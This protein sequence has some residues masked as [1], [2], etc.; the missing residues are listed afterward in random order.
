ME[1]LKSIEGESG[2]SALMGA[3]KEY[4]DH[5]NWGRVLGRQI[6]STIDSSEMN[7][8]YQ[9]E[10]EE[11]AQLKKLH[12][13]EDK[14]G[15]LLT[16]LGLSLEPVNS[17]FSMF[18]TRQ[19]K[20]EEVEERVKDFIE[21][22]GI[23][24]EDVGDEDTYEAKRV[25]KFLEDLSEEAS[26]SVRLTEMRLNISD[27]TKFVAYLENLKTGS[28]DQTERDSLK[29]LS[30]ILEQQLIGEYDVTNPSDDRFLNLVGSLGK[31]VEQYE[32]L[33]IESEKLKQLLDITRQG[34]LKDFLLVERQN[35]LLPYDQGFGPARWHRDM[36][37]D[38]YE[39]NW[40]KAIDIYNQTLKN[41]K[42]HEL[43]EKLRN[44]LLEAIKIA[45]G[46]IN[47]SEHL[48]TNHSK[49]LH[50]LEKVSTVLAD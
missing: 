26:R 25:G 12:A 17:P 14:Y 19:M 7:P 37:D 1:K 46:E 16:Q 41:P 39:R 32:R 44:H 18:G 50:T 13:L 21:E 6:S 43:S 5:F 38:N 4:N 11:A 27:S 35:Y 3:L 20:K 31:I 42:A 2:V 9:E 24:A 23:T 36:T 48:K 40:R 29:E 49:F 28:V 47:N 30:K 8:D 15:T 33:G 34:Y 22:T 10:D 45:R